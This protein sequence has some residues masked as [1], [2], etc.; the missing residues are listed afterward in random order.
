MFLIGLGM[1][2]VMPT[3]SIASQNSA[4]PR[5]MGIATSAQ[6]F[7]RSLGSSIG[8][9][10]YGTIFN[11]V[12]RTELTNRPPKSEASGDLLSIIRQP[13]EIQKLAPAARNAVQVSISKGASHIFFLSVFVGVV[14]FLLAFRLREEPLR[15]TTGLQQRAAM[16]E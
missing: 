6:N 16:T 11:S 7:F 10:V 14:A 1:G 15:N 12:V 9:A 2:C 4:D 8:L 3:L 5:D 13:S